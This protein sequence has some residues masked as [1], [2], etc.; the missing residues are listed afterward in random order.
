MITYNMHIAHVYAAVL[1][2]VTASDD[3]KFVHGYL[4]KERTAVMFWCSRRR[5]SLD[6]Q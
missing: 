3:A 2:I 1:L 6:T 4:D 5:L